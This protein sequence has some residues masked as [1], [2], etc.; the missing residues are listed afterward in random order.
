MNRLA[1]GVL[2]W[3]HVVLV[4]AGLFTLLG[5]EVF[6]WGTQGHRLV[7][8]IA[9]GQ[10]T[11]RAR[12]QV[13]RLLDGRT[14][15]NVSS[16]AD[17]Y[18]DDVYQTSWW[19]FVNLPDG[20]TAYDRDRDCPR[21]PQV[22]PG[23]RADRWRDCVVDRIDYARQRLANQ[24]LDRADRATSLKFLVHLVGDLH[25]P[26]H[27]VLA[28]RGG[29]DTTVRVFGSSNCAS[30]PGSKSPCNLHGAWDS[31]LIEHRDLDDRAYLQL[32]APVVAREQAALRVGVPA[33]WALESL[34]VARAGTVPAGTNLDEAYFRRHIEAIDRRLVQGGLR[35]GALVNE[36]LDSTE[37]R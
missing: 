11:P 15:A 8:L 10:L 24:A 2:A 34:A 17:D 6:G 19:H 22:A 4:A 29:N 25:Q 18:R 5:Q 9:A 13:N 35:L 16:W 7:G 33:E 14:L 12:D 20:A 36:A 26:F 1:P 32:L 3:R 21:Q 31:R 30:R 28:A 37:R 27:A 23:N